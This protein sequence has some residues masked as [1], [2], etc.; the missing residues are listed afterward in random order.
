MRW[1]EKDLTRFTLRIPEDLHR[2]I[3]KKI[4]GY[5]FQPS[6]NE[7]IIRVLIRSLDSPIPM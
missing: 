5:A 2:K 3:N 4:E 1:K 7:Y 6:M